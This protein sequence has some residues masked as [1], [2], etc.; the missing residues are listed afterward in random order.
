[1]ERAIETNALTKSYGDVV[2]LDSLSI[3]VDAGEVFGFLGPNGAGKTTTIDILLD[4]IRPTSG[5]ASIMGYDTQ[6]E[7]GA[8]RER[9]GVLPDGFDLWGRSSGY[10]HLEF[11]RRS[12]GADDDPD[13]LLERVGLDPEDAERPVSNYSKGMYQRLGMAMA[14][15]G[16]PEVLIL[17][18]PSTGLDPH[19]IRTMQDIVREEAAGGTTVFFSSHLLEQ[20]EAVCD[21]VAIL[22]DGAL[23]TVDSIG[24]LRE[25]AGLGSQLVVEVTDVPEIDLTTIDGVTAVTTEAGRLRVTYTDPTAKETVITRLSSAGA[26]VRDFTT[27]EPSLEDLFTAYTE[28]TTVEV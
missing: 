28:P 20:V 8:V 12:K 2:A 4:F 10:S 24:G 14:L 3:T 22:K 21:R 25:T 19:G 16:D 17:D 23:L 5:S 7:T 6:C 27:D 9:V 15:V 13:E 18:E 26:G 1:M 11:A